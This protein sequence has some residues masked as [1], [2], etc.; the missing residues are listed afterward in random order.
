LEKRRS[1]GIRKIRKAL[2]WGNGEE[3]ELEKS[4][5]IKV[6]GIRKIRKD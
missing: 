1:I 2:D 6:D 4:R 5:N 3:S